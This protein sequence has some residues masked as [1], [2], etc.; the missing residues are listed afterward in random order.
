MWRELIS[1]LSEDCEFNPPAA[2]V[3]ILAAEESLGLTS[4][5]EL[6]GLFKETNGVSNKYGSGL[7]WS[8][9]RIQH[10]NIE[11]RTTEDFRFVYAV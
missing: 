2:F 7:I 6:K 4:P 1:K 10:D 8:T 3:E 5:D 9:E 11:F